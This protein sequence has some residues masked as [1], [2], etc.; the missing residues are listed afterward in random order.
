MY[1][2][3]TGSP[4]HLRWLRVFEPLMILTGIVQPLSAPCLISLSTFLNCCFRGDA[5]AV[6]IW[7][8]S[9][10]GRIHE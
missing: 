10:A 5:A 9:V 6:A 2:L 7:R 4:A 8:G 1:F 3:K